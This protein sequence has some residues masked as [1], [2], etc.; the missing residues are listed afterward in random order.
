MQSLDD[1]ILGNSKLHAQ[2]VTATRILAMLAASA[3]Q[4]V[5]LA[6]MQRDSGGSARELRKICEDFNH[7]GYT[8][9][10]KKM[11]DAWML[12]CDL[13]SVTLAD[14][15]LAAIASPGKQSGA[16]AT[17]ATAQASRQQNNLDLILMQAT[18]TINQSLFRL[19]RQFTLDRLNVAATTVA[20]SQFNACATHHIRSRDPALQDW[21]NSAEPI[22]GPG[23][24]IPPSKPA[25]K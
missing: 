8:S 9:T 22:A 14:V 10:P 15:Y 16:G 24:G 6:T 20:E 3:P 23:L 21:R 5:T 7:A 4:C 1:Y 25:P 13:S 17:G 2:L 11:R 18:M 19:L 12:H